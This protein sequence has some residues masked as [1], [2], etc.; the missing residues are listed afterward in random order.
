MTK[1]RAD[2]P[3]LVERFLTYAKIDTQS[4]EHSETRPSTAKQHEMLDLLVKELQDL[5][6]EEVEKT[7]YAAVMATL[8]ANMP[9]DFPASEKIPTIG[10]ISHVDTYHGTSGA[11][12]KPT[13]VE[14]YGGEKI[15]LNEEKGMVLDPAV[16]EGLKKLIGND[17]IHT[18][19]TT[20]LGADDK[21]GVAEIMDAVT[22]LACNPDIPHGEIRIAFTVDEEIGR[23]ADDFD[24]EHFR[25]KYSYT[26][27]GSVLG[28]VE[29]ET[30]CADSARVKITGYDVHP[31]Y[32]KDKLINAIRMASEI[33]GNMQKDKLPETTEKKQGYLHAIEIKG[34][35]SE[36][37]ITFLVRD[38]EESGLRTLEGI[39][40]GICKDAEKKFPGSKVEMSIKEFYRNMK[41]ELDKHPMVMEIARRAMRDLG[42]EPITKPIRGGTD[43]S[44]LTLMGMPTPN[45][46]AGGENFHSVKEYLSIQTMEKARDVI[47]EI[48]KLW[49]KAAADGEI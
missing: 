15:I 7:D 38:F 49:A 16:D 12:V 9:Q 20:L 39:L 25:A 33:V 6:L 30:F 1:N 26:M 13:I 4:D 43:G 18:D 46:F 29:D 47:L 35:V 11:N 19:G 3:T 34:N 22:E 44:R 42:I 5:G 24:L 37:E 40:E 28:E 10:F 45:I 21:A 32:A 8:P 36:V 48:S 14:N 27:D 2:F 41:Y 23:G 17:I 31:G